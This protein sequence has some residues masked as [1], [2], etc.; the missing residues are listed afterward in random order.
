MNSQ[1]RKLGIV[2]LVLFS[3]L[4]IQ[5]NYLQV[6]DA[7]DLN[8]HPSTSR[9]VVR[10]FVQPR[11]VIQTADGRHVPPGDGWCRPRCASAGRG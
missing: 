4:F 6:I 2:L 3:A 10:D 7:N 11:G 9:A 5:L 1:I 8:N